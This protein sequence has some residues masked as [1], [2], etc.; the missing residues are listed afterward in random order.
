MANFCAKCGA[1]LHASSTFCGGCGSPVRRPSSTSAEPASSQASPPHVMSSALPQKSSGAVKVLV[2]LLAVIFVGV[3][4]ALGGVIYVAHKVSQRAHNFSTRVLRNSPA[5]GGL[6]SLLSGEPA[7]ET[8]S[9]GLSGDPC[10]FLTKEEVSHAIGVP[11][12]AVNRSEGGCEYLAKGSSGEMTAKHMASMM[13]TKGADR[14]QQ[15]MI[16]KISGGLFSSLQNESREATQDP[17]G[18]SVVFAFSVDPASARTQMR[19]NRKVLGGLGPGSQNLP[20]IGDEAFDV[21]GAML[22]VRKGDRVIRIS[23]M[24]CPCT[25]DA[26]KPLAQKLAS[27]L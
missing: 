21:A 27:A 9:P 10:R 26:V 1:P 19:L 20:G 12:V 13:G 24:S 18:N 7:A 16:E 23:Y 22:M 4:L 25:I 11:I 14:G 6:G 2:T 8:A 3:A 17:S 15:Q 5:S